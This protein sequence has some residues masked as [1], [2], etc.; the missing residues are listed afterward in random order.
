MES[1][2]TETEIIEHLGKLEKSLPKANIIVLS[3]PLSFKLKKTNV[4][5][6]KKAITILF[7][8]LA[9][10]ILFPPFFWPVNGRVSSGFLFRQKP[11]S[12][13]LGIEVHHG[14][15]IAANK[16]TNIFPTAIGQVIES[17][18]ANDLGNYVRIKHLFGFE[19][20]YAHMDTIKVKKYSIVY[21]GLSS[22]GTVGNT[23]R[24]TGPHLHFGVYAFGTP[25]PPK[26]ML[27]FHS[28]RKG[29]IGF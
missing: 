25:C 13:T 14:I 6:A 18:T 28:I 8:T 3:K 9:F 15:D 22:I 1:N 23:G 19:S 5:A 17:G 24:S 21:P 2:Q 26:A 16:G 27:L 12:T 11:D 20:I 7:V 4:M 29:I 10:F